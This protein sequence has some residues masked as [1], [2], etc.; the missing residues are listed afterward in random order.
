M[1]DCVPLRSKKSGDIWG[2]AVFTRSI[3][4]GKTARLTL[5]SRLYN[6]NPIQKSDVIYASNV[7]KERDYWY[8]YEYEK[9]I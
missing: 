2:Y 8:L 3:G 5:R 9:V 6:A 1:N 7:G 4:S